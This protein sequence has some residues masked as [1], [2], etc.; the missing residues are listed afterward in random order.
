FR[1][2]QIPFTTS[3]DVTEAEYW[4]RHVREAVRFH[5]NVQALGGVAFLEI[6]PDGVLS[7]MVT[8]DVADA[9]AIPVLR[10]DKPEETA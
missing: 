3:G 1:E 10:K 6:G 5:D 9:V 7:A 2:P 4:V 8:Q